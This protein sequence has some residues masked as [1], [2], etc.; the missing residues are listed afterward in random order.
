VPVEH[1]EQARTVLA[2]FLAA[3]A[4]RHTEVGPDGVQRPQHI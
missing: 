3:P 2:A 1:L 4:F